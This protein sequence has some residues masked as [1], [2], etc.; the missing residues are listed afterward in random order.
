MRFF[1]KFAIF[2]G[3]FCILG[4]PAQAGVLLD[5]LK[6]VLPNVAAIDHDAIS[7]DT[8]GEHL[9]RLTIEGNGV[10][11]LVEDARL[12][13]GQDGLVLHGRNM[14]FTAASG[15]VRADVLALSQSAVTWMLSSSDAGLPSNP[16]F[17]VEGLA[18]EMFSGPTGGGESLL[19]DRLAVGQA[20]ETGVLALQG[21]DLSLVAAGGERLSL[22][23]IRANFPTLGGDVLD[24][25]RFGLQIDTIS[26]VR[27]DGESILQLA[28]L[29]MS[30]QSDRSLNVPLLPKTRIA[31]A[32]TI[33]NH[34]VASNLGIKVDFRGLILPTDNLLPGEMGKQ[35]EAMPG[36]ALTGD[37]SF[38][39]ALSS[40]QF[41]LGFDLRMSGL[42][43][44]AGRLAARLMPFDAV[45]VDR[46]EA[47]IQAEISDIPAI[48]L[49]ELELHYQSKGLEELIAG[50]GSTSLRTLI[51]TGME[52]IIARAGDAGGAARQLLAA[53]GDWIDDGGRKP[54]CARA[55]IGNAPVMLTE[56]LVITL[57]SP[58]VAG[59]QLAMTD[60]GCR[61][62]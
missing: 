54:V 36:S 24:W 43:D 34:L 11:L 29:F 37:G 16:A 1:A 27:S 53:I 7:V 59:A 49:Q 28:S 17:A 56:I 35:L 9:G 22:G 31:R 12:A 15:R 14:I 41:A 58:D 52:P 45:R 55:R 44:L 33:Y 57:L 42:L 6:A 8:G 40:G 4:L 18:I 46:L 3:V 48:F 50:L 20:S 39:L 51:E 10:D 2:A 30:L 19:A 21:S 25:S 60:Q 32:L 13:E 62:H 38:E 26:A 23:A 47:D 61:A 5:R